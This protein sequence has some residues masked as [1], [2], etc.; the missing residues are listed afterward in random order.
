MREDMAKV[1]VERPR[2]PAFKVRKGRDRSIEDLPF[3]EGMR[4]GHALHGDRKELNENLAP[5]RRFLESQVGRPWNKV[6]AEISAHLRVDS[7]VQKHVRDHL[8]DFV[9]IKPR[10]INQGWR[11]TGMDDLWWQRLYVHP[12]TGLLCRTD[13]LPEE[14]ARR[15]RIASRP[16]KPVDRI[17][18]TDVLEFRRIKGI[19]YEVELAAMPDA[20]YKS[21]QEIQTRPLRQYDRRSPT[22]EVEVTVCRLVTPAVHDV[23][24]G[25]M[26]AVG[27]LID[28]PSYWYAHRRAYPDRRY[29]I[30]KRTLSRRELREHDLKND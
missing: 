13:R 28:K 15:R 17:A 7:A 24:S 19:W 4:R 14:R 21:Y 10:R 25:G 29:G 3:R 11:P 6:Y 22:I 27:P 2:I 16:K 26:I 8:R 30:S 23:V 12:V 20:V 9:A 5:L 18:V 1:I